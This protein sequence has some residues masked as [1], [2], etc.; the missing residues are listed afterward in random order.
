MKIVGMTED[1]ELLRRLQGKRQGGLLEPW[2]FVLTKFNGEEKTKAQGNYVV[3][4]EVF[5]EGDWVT[6]SSVVE[7]HEKEGIVE[8]RN[9]YYMVGPTRRD[10]L[11]L[12]HL[13]DEED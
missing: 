13:D 12:R 1:L 11:D 3:G 10:D 6:T 8:T 5:E 9:T 4:D 2:R 7:Y